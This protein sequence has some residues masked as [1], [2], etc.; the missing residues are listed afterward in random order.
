MRW[1]GFRGELLNPD[2][3]PAPF[4]LSEVEGHLSAK[5]FDLDQHER[6]GMIDGIAI[7]RR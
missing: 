4:G 1:S 3:S 7:V 6:L 2:P 5:C